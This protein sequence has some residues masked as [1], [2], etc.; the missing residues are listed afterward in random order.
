MLPSRGKQVC[1]YR[2]ASFIISLQ[3]TKDGGCGIIPISCINKKMA[4]CEK[5]IV[6]TFLLAALVA[7]GTS[8][9]SRLPAVDQSFDL[10]I[11]HPSFEK[12]CRLADNLQQVHAIAPLVEMDLPISSAREFRLL[13]RQLNFATPLL[14][15]VVSG[16]LT[17]A[18][19]NSVNAS[20]LM[21][22]MEQILHQ[23]CSF[24]LGFAVELRHYYLYSGVR[25]QHTTLLVGCG[26]RFGGSIKTYRLSRGN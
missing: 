19:T 16:I 3:W 8:L 1:T 25:R 26:Q 17:T 24:V 12:L 7:C 15:R 9:C 2:T 18:D 5:R 23:V 11:A 10:L 20:R 4:F 22:R 6:A 14:G 21:E 13:Q